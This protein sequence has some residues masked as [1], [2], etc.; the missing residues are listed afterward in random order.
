MAKY[1]PELEQYQENLYHLT[2]TLPNCK[3]TDLRYTY[4][5]IAKAFKRLI[6]FLNGDLKIKD[7]SFEEWGYMGAVRSLEVTF[8]EDSYHPH[9]HVGLV[10]QKSLGKKNIENKYSWDFKKA[11]P[12]LKRLFCEEEILIQKIWFLLLNGIK[13]TKKEIES[14]ELGYSCTMDKFQPGDYAELFKYMTK[15]TNEKGKVLSYQNFVN[16]LHGLYNVKQIQG[17]GCLYRIKDEDNTEEYER[18]YDEMIQEIRAKENPA[19]A[20]QTPRELLSD[21]EYT[22]ISR[23]SY[24]K[25]LKTL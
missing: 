4:D 2:L 23:K 11:I 15:E 16:L 21:S 6:R 12:E 9:L 24:F 3:G 13:V 7:L 25:Y 18:I 5:K 17:Y 8:N 20:Y 1:I 19:M 14:L 10:M 22:L